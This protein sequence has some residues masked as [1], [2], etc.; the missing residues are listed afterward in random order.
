MPFFTDMIGDSAEIYIK[1]LWNSDFVGD[2]VE[3]VYKLS[4]IFED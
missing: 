2:S 3:K 1:V 4:V